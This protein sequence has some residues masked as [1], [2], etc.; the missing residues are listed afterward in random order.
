MIGGPGGRSRGRGAA[1]PTEDAGLG[2]SR[3]QDRPADPRV[4]RGRRHSLVRR[5]SRDPRRLD[6][7]GRA[8][9]LAFQIKDDLLDVESDAATLGKNARQGRRRG[10]GDVPGRL[11]RRALA[12]R[13]WRRRSRRRSRRRRGSRTRGGR[14]PDL[15][16]FVGERGRSWSVR[17]DGVGEFSEQDA[18]GPTPTRARRGR[19]PAGAHGADLRHGPEAAVARAPADHAPGHDGPRAVRRSRRGRGRASTRRSSASASCPAVTGPCGRCADCRRR[20]RQPLPGGPRRPDLGRLRRVRARSRRRRRRRTSTGRPPRSPTK[21]RPSSIPS[22][23][24]STAGTGSAP[25]SGAPADLRLGGARAAL[26][27]DGAKTRGVARSSPAGGPS[28]CTSPP[29]AAPRCSTSI[30]TS[31]RT[32]SR[33]RARCP[34]RLSTARGT[35]RSGCGCRTSCAMA[36]AS[37]SSAAARP[38]RGRH[39]DAARLHYAELSLIGSF[40]YTPEEAR[41][42]MAAAR[43]GRDRSARPRDRS[44]D[45][46]SDLP[47]FLEAQRR[48]RRHPLRQVRPD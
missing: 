45:S 27:G 14:L 2:D 3:E 37:C 18:A 15:A 1:A 7:Y 9:G 8:I 40:H 44:R 11:G 39:Y 19:R 33:A 24:S 6:R 46:L 35:R 41:E 13:C 16:R 28:G 32:S 22:P 43:L 26:G 47:R 29:A 48:A 42:A 36:A 17:P 31:R 30:A 20:P 5:N 34:T 12:P 21:P 23:R 25:S 38:G 4:A 10:Q